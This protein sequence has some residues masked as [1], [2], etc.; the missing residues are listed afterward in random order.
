MVTSF[1]DGSKIVCVCVGN[2][3]EGGWC[4]G[5]DSML[6]KAYH[7]QFSVYNNYVVC[8]NIDPVHCLSNYNYY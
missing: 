2:V 3:F 1:N 8:S 7:I 4:S 5:L 6:I